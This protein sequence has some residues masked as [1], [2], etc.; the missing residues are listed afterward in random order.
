MSNL[1]AH[2][3]VRSALDGEFTGKRPRPRSNCA[4][5]ASLRSRNARGDVTR[6]VFLQKLI[7]SIAGEKI[8][9]NFIP[10]ISSRFAMEMSWM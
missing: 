7:E 10:L 6:A 9:F 3:H 8:A 1:S 5:Y 2:E 4:F